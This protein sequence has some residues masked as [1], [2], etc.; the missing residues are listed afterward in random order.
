ME[1]ETKKITK[2]VNSYGKLHSSGDLPS[3]IEISPKGGEIRSWHRNGRLHRQEKDPN[4][5]LTLPAEIYPGSSIRKLRE[6]KKWSR[7]GKMYRD[8]KDE[9]GFSLPTLDD[10]INGKIWF[11][12]NYRHREEK[13]EH[14]LTLPAVICVDGSKEW[15]NNGQL[16]RVDKDLITGFLLPADEYW[17]I[18]YKNGIRYNKD[19]T[20]YNHPNSD[21]DMSDQ[22]NSNEDIP[23]QD[24]SNVTFVLTS[25]KHDESKLED[26]TCSICLQQMLT[27]H[28]L[29]KTS[30]NHVYH[31]KCIKQCIEKTG[32]N[33]PLCRQKLT[34]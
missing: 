33:C 16:H 22:D 27:D 20:I 21:E 34:F 4:T 19:D 26:T 12:G 1:V 15:W 32:K 24:N 5:G 8:D 3:L 2:T 6:N 25:Y 10:D 23:N 17:G 14:G 31:T 11:K 13:D 7:N 18:F 9:N 30:C 29:S 28:Y